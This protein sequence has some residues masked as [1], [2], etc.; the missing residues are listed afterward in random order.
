MFC[1]LTARGL[2]VHRVS[3]RGNQQDV[4]RDLRRRTKH[5]GERDRPMLQVHRQSHRRIE[6]A[7]DGAD[8]HAGKAREPVLRQP[9]VGEPGISQTHHRRRRRVPSAA[10]LRRAHLGEAARVRRGGGAVPVRAAVRGRGGGG[11]GHREDRRGFRDGGGDYPRELRGHVPLRGAHAPR[12]VQNESGET[13]GAGAEQRGARCA[14]GG[15][16]RGRAGG[17]VVTAHLDKR[18]GF[19]AL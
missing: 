8:D 1:L 19:R 15:A 10:R 3:A 14:R 16:R 11:G 6:H 7:D 13:A 12:G 9:R 17:A 4:Q 18:E 2:P 5:H